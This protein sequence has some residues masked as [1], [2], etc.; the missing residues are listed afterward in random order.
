MNSLSAELNRLQAENEEL[1]KKLERSNDAWLRE[2]AENEELKKDVKRLVTAIL[3][4]TN[5]TIDILGIEDRD[6]LKWRGMDDL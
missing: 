3:T 2:R 5:S 1:L 6:G 4:L